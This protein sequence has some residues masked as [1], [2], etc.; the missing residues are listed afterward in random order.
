MIIYVLNPNLFGM[1]EL[2]K[3]IILRWET[4]LLE[5]LRIYANQ[6]TEY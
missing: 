6:K 1:F 4:A 3:K 2:K 5:Y